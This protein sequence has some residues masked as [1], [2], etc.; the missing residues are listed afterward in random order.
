MHKH[1][2][3]SNSN[4]DYGNLTGISGSEIKKIL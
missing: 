1:G 4:D 2:N 3:E